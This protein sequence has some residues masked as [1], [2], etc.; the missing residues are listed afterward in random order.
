M[1]KYNNINRIIKRLKE[2]LIAT[3][4]IRKKTSIKEAYITLWAKTNI[5]IINKK[6]YKETANQTK[7]LKRKHEILRK[8]F[9]KTFSNFIQSYQVNKN[10]NMNEKDYSDCIWICWWQ[11][12]ENAP[13]IVKNC[14]NSIKKHCG[15]HR[16]II[17]DEQ[18]YSNYVSFPDWILKKFEEGIIT[19]TNLSDLLRLSLLAQHGGLWIDSTFFCTSDEIQNYFKLPLWTI[20]RPD[21]GHLSVAC[22]NFAGYS[23][24]TNYENRYIFSVIRDYFLNY[25]KSNNKLVDYLLVD[26]MIDIVIQ[27]YPFIKDKF[28]K[29]ESNNKNC[30]ELYKILGQEYNDVVWSNIKK[31]TCLFKL[32]WKSKFPLKSK[33][34]KET[35][36]SM[37]INDKLR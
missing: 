24:Y 11:G 1:I 27:S 37:I 29:I 22:G 33:N 35:F 18:N 7:L 21:Y 2:E 28:E 5:Q 36:F 31:D 4:E 25:W 10:Q 34:N 15:N 30:D 3:N 6:G 14:I 13:K 12:I 8:Y 17:I 26:Y 9:K 20:K 19:R 32:T 23:L 16:I